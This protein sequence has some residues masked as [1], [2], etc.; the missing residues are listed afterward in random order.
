MEEFQIV[1]FPFLPIC[2]GNVSER[3]NYLDFNS[4]YTKPEQETMKSAIAEARWLK[5]K[6]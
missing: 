2:Q 1:L 3:P 4:Y 5:Y 6:T